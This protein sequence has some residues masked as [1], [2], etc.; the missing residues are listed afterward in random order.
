[1]A[2]GSQRIH[3]VKAAAGSSAPYLLSSR[4]LIR[5]QAVSGLSRVPSEAFEN[6]QAQYAQYGV[7]YLCV[8]QPF[9]K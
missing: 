5:M 3:G 9:R 8:V 7:E 1:M 4:T 2:Y 6:S